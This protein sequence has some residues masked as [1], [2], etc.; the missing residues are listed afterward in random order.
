[1]SSATGS[2]APHAGPARSPFTMQPHARPWARTVLLAC[3]IAA[4]VIWVSIDI[5]AAMMT[6]GYSY[7]SQAI[8]ELSAIGAPSRSLVQAVVLV[9]NPLAIAFG[10]GVWMGSSGRRALRVTAVLLV[11]LAA[12][13]LLWPFAPMHARGTEFGLTDVLH[14]VL[15]TVTVV[16]TLLIVGIGSVS[17]GTPFRLYSWA[18]LLALLIFGALTY[19][20]APAVAAGQPTPGMGL[21]ERIN[22]YGSLLWMA[23][24]AVML[25]REQRGRAP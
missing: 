18:T 4:P 16:S 22:A 15:A 6:E 14:I 17:F 7:T 21:Y 5:V 23:V 12:V 19:L 2:A 11:A 13:G 3:G 8:S 24:L 9:Y 20:Y 1:M 10:V 25:L